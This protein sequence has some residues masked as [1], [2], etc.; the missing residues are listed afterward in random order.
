MLLKNPSI[1]LIKTLI[2]CSVSSLC[3]FLT[4]KYLRSGPCSPNL[5]IVT[6]LIIWITS[7]VLI[8][9]NIYLILIT[10]D[11]TRLYSIIALLA[12]NVSFYYT[13][14]TNKY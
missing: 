12:F 14:L 7:I 2:Y 5:D 9:R 3:I 1:G 10:K 11:T 8:C 13:I 4:S 6:Y